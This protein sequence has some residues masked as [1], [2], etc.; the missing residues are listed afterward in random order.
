M[1]SSNNRNVKSKEKELPMLDNVFLKMS[2]VLDKAKIL[3]TKRAKV[4]ESS[5]D[6]SVVIPIL[7]VIPKSSKQ[8]YLEEFKIIKAI[9]NNLNISVS[10][11]GCEEK[12]N[13]IKFYTVFIFSSKRLTDEEAKGNEGMYAKHL[14]DYL[15]QNQLPKQARVLNKS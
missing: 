3:N 13:Q 14:Q 7:D 2:S 15:K 4:N 8:E 5:N 11:K 9:C 12:N 6:V 1:M 10:I